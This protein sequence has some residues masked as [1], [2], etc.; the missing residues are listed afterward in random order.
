[1][2]GSIADSLFN[3]LL[4]YGASLYGRPRT[5]AQEPISERIYRLQM[6][7]NRMIRMVTHTS[8]KERKP[9]TELRASLGMMSVNQIIIYHILLDTFNTLRFDSCPQ[10]KQVLT[11]DVT[12][13]GLCTRSRTRGDLNIVGYK[14]EKFKGIT[15]HAAS[16]WNS[17]PKS[18][19]EATQYSLFKKH[20]KQWALSMPQ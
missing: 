3:S 13:S 18:I 17:A 16:L 2:V 7:Q 6:A 11:E 5:T 12:S 14:K 1:M 9:M 20:A 8:L 4:R 19:R 10:L 15:Q